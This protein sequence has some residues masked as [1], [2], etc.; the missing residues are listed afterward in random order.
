MLRHIVLLRRSK[1]P[2]P[3]CFSIGKRF[4]CGKRFGCH[5]KQRRFRVEALE[6][7]HHVVAVYVRD[8]AHV[9]VVLIEFQRL[10]HHG[11]AKIGT[12]DADVHYIGK[13]LAGIP[14]PASAD[15]FIAKLL[16]ASKLLFSG[17]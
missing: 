6:A 3:R 5:Y 14:F 12:A 7:F 15:D 16:I 8:E 13:G 9:Q 10:H 2:F 17:A 4:L 1:E 11:R